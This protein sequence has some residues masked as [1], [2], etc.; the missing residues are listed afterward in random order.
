LEDRDV[1]QLEGLL[2]RMLMSPIPH[3]I[4]GFVYSVLDEMEGNDRKWWVSP[5]PLVLGLI[6]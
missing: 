1:T 2:A 5:P 4:R 3:E 6:V